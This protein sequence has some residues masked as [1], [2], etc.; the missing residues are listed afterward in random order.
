MFNI[1]IINKLSCFLVLAVMSVSLVGCI[2]TRLPVVAP[3]YPPPPVKLAKLPRVALVLG[4]G[5][6]RGYAHLG[7]LQALEEGGIHVDL[8]AGCSAG[9]VV[10]ALYADNG[11]AEE[12]KEIML[13]AGFWDFTELSNVGYFGF[14]IGSNFES[15]MLKH[16]HAKTFAGLRTKLIVATTDINSGATYIIQSGPV[17][18]ALLASSAIPGFVSPVKLY[19]RT[20]IDGGV[21]D[22]VPVNL[23]KPFH[24]KVIIAVNLTSMVNGDPPTT[25]LGV[26]HEAI[27]I[28]LRNITKES[29]RGADVVISPEVGNDTFDTSHRNEFYNAGLIAGRK[30]VKKIKRLLAE[31]A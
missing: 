24:P 23:V 30:A 10:A 4:A 17:A 28:M 26:S 29:L 22:P 16:M 11:S 7:V 19:H 2:G 3:D 9:S 1:N 5:G 13:H 20:L 15:F 27:E 31:R 21:S 25:A 18:P 14:I 6:A 12:T 8:L